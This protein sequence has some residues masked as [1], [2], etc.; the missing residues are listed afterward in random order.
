MQ[1]TGTDVTFNDFFNFV[2]SNQGFLVIYYFAQDTKLIV[3]Q[4]TL[5]HT[6][7]VKS[8][9]K[10]NNENS[11]GVNFRLTG[12]YGLRTHVGSNTYGESFARGAFEYK[13][14]DYGIEF[15]VTTKYDGKDIALHTNDY[16]KKIRFRDVYYTG[17]TVEGM[18]FFIT[19]NKENNDTKRLVLE[20]EL[21]QKRENLERELAEIR[22]QEEINAINKKYENMRY[23]N[24]YPNHYSNQGVQQNQG[25][26]Q[27]YYSDSNPNPNIQTGPMPIPIVVPQF[28]QPMNPPQ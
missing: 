25:L 5:E 3:T 11:K 2:S 18:K 16:I 17:N 28:Q 7:L 12:L 19:T 27:Y 24:Q 22:R 14:D 6:P 13:F 10:L 9:M 20:Y 23:H 1:Q 26:S 15:K 4:D 8:L 21:M